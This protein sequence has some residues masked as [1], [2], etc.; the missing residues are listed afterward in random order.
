MIAA[1]KSGNALLQVGHLERFNPA[2]VALRPHV[3]K[4]VYFGDSPGR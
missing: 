4:P 1:A 3:K 2:M